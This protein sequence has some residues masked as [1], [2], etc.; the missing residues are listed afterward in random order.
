M[1]FQER[2]VLLGELEKARKKSTDP[3]TTFVGIIA[4]TLLSIDGSLQALVEL[5]TQDDNDLR[6]FLE[7]IGEPG[8]MPAAVV[9]AI[10]APDETSAP[11]MKKRGTKKVE[12][13]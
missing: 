1:N 12:G 10:P 6:E 9:A 3:M 13:D 8:V 2:D 5:G 7:A 4:K 11:P